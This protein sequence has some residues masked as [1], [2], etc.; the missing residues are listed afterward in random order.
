[1]R[2]ICRL[3]L[4][5]PGCNAAK[6]LIRK[7]RVAQGTPSDPVQAH[8]DGLARTCEAAWEAEG[9]LTG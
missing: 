6:T 3:I 4:L 5:L 7:P 8:D 9:Q 1:M 2:P